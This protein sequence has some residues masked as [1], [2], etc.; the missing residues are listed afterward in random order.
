[1]VRLPSWEASNDN[2]D[3]FRTN[4][5]PFSR[6]ISLANRSKNI[7]QED[8]VQ[9]FP[10]Y[11]IGRLG[12]RN[13]IKSA[14]KFQSRSSGRDSRFLREKKRSRNRSHV[15]ETREK[16]PMARRGEA[17]PEARAKRMRGPAVSRVFHDNLCKRQFVQAVDAQAASSSRNSRYIRPAMHYREYDIHLTSDA[18]GSYGRC[19][20]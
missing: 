15:E 12:I 20:T 8:I 13:P 7:I 16:G 4:Y 18:R 11:E 17:G 10:N 19:G 2:N 1:M 9:P 14:R 6:K 5:I 3:L